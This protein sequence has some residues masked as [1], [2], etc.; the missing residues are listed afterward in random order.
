MSTPRRAL[1]AGVEINIP[2]TIEQWRDR[3]KHLLDENYA[4]KDLDQRKD[5][6]SPDDLRYMKRPF[7]AG[8]S[9]LDVED[10]NVPTQV[11]IAR[12]ATDQRPVPLWVN[13][14][15]AITDLIR[16]QFPRL[17]RNSSETQSKQAA[18]WRHIL[19]GMRRGL[20]ASE[21]A[22]EWDELHGA[23]RGPSG[24]RDLFTPEERRQWEK[25]YGWTPPVK[26][27]TSD[28]DAAHI[29][30]VIQQIRCVVAG[31]STV[32][33]PKG[34]RGRPKNPQVI[35]SKAVA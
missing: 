35:D 11:A 27:K 23:D 33:K 25:E 22:R 10:G 21:I 32:C 9:G 29:R 18:L 28:V 20:P 8:G 13:N 34:K 6:I 15:D 5:Q 3:Y 4:A 26:K 12:D 19:N 17:R 24:S 16:I 1:V 31:L 7:E 30:R 14:E 2:A